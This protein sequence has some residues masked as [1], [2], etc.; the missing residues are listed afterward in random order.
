M[1]SGGV[2]MGRAQ[3]PQSSPWSESAGEP[4]AIGER[5]VLRGCVLRAKSREGDSCLDVVCQGRHAEKDKVHQDEAWPCCRRGRPSQMGRTRLG[6][7][8]KEIKPGELRNWAGLL[9]ITS[10]GRGDFF[11]PGS[12]SSGAE[13]IS[14]CIYHQLLIHSNTFKCF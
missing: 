3:P 7:A 4:A 11:F 8:L 10:T 9:L 13:G 14:P 12:S 5:S 2:Q 6:H 1:D